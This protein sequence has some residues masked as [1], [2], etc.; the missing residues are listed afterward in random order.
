M[1]KEWVQELD[2]SRHRSFERLWY[3]TLGYYCLG[4][5]IPATEFVLVDAARALPEDPEIR[6]ALGTYLE[7]VGWTQK[8][9]K[10][11]K[12]A[13][14]EFRHV[15]EIQPD[16]AEVI[17]RLGRILTLRGE[18]TEALN[19]LKRGLELTDEPMLELVA[20]LS[21][22]DIYREQ[23]ELA[24]AAQSYQT[25][26]DIDP[27]C[28]AAMV[29]L[30]LTLHKAG[31]AQGSLG[32]IENYFSTQEVPPRPAM[33]SLFTEQHDLLWRYSLGHS[34]RFTSFRVQLR[35]MVAQ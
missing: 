22:G 27:R 15:L 19:Q 3:L 4:S 32:V 5:L 30:A 35:G 2:P 8:D 12:E 13:E 11:L 25:A 29:A 20:H 23:K 31:D 14:S 28:Q 18:E 34:D 17:V 10:H 7:T 21:L 24:R 1:A 16:N 9:A 26:M 6:T 33:T